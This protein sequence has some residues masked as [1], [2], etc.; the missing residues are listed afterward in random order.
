MM[1]YNSENSYTSLRQRVFSLLND[2]PW[3]TAKNIC[4]ILKLSYKQH[5][6]YVNNLKYSWKSNNK[7]EHG[8]MCSSVHGWRGARATG[9]NK[10]PFR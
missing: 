6:A 4:R 9:S 1:Y 7:D 3:L 10:Q 5:Y 8:L 2:Q